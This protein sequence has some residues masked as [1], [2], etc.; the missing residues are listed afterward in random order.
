MK[1]GQIVKF[2]NINGTINGGTI[3]SFQK[4]SNGENIVLINTLD[5]KKVS[6]LISDCI[7]I[8]HQITGKQSKKFIDSVKKEIE[9][10]NKGLTQHTPN[11]YKY[12]EE[13]QLWINK[14]NEQS[15]IID[16]Q[17]HEIEILIKENNDLIE[18]FQNKQKQYN[19]LQEEF[20][21]YKIENKNSIKTIEKLQYIILNMKKAIIAGTE[22]KNKEQIEALLDIITDFN[23]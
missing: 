11:D 17:K 12:K 7:K 8:G 1:V 9:S 15:N 2:K 3:T 18:K 20:D 19:S 14:Y 10:Y 6:V 22:N 21:K 4:N 5:N 16:K 13:I 23:C